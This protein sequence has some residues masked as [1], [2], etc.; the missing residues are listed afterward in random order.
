ML[1]VL[2]L[3]VLLDMII[4]LGQ[5]NQPATATSIDQILKLGNLTG[6]MVPPSFLED[7]C[8]D[9]DMLERVRALKYVHYVG[10]PLD[11]GVG[12]L[13]WG[14]VKLLSAIGS[15]E[16][17]FYFQ[18]YH[19]EPEWYYH[20][21]CPSMGLTFETRAD[22]LY[23]A[24]FCR[25]A[26]LERWQQIFTVYPNLERFPTNDLMTRHRTNPDLWAYAGRTDDLISFSHSN[27]YR[28]SGIEAAIMSHPD[29]QAAVV[30]GD[31]RARPF[32]ILDV[33][34]DRIPAGVGQHDIDLIEHVWP[35]V[36]EAN[37][38][39]KEMV[40][41]KK[42]LTILVAPDK[43]IERTAKGTVSRRAAIELYKNE[44]DEAYKRS[45]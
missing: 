44:V 16:A 7:L 21:F 17:G 13:L 33:R 39:C 19:G 32:L 14:H 30:G 31:G 3:P 20:H 36:N 28:V 40:R 25:K 18:Q 1:M 29:V 23:E 45:G 34:R 26:G 41:L 6:M 15:T 24:V 35:V 42:E 9:A 37:E 27:S 8:R 5:A 4:V 10:A 22:D 2:Q 11:K 38:K 12:D 43:P